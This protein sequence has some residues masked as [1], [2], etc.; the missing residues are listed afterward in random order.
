[1]GA[2]Q[3]AAV[4]DVSRGR[5]TVQAAAFVDS[6]L[7]TAHVL[8]SSFHGLKLPVID[9]VTARVV[10]TATSR[11]PEAALNANRVDAAACPGRLFGT[12]SGLVLRLSWLVGRMLGTVTASL[13]Y[14]N[15][16]VRTL[17]HVTLAV[18][19]QFKPPATVVD[20]R[21]AL[22]VGAH[23]L[24]NVTSSRSRISF[25]SPRTHNLS[26]KVVPSRAM[27][28]GVS[29]PTAGSFAR[30]RLGGSRYGRNILG[31]GTPF[32]VHIVM[33]AFY[34]SRQIVLT[35]EPR[36]AALGFISRRNN[37]D[38]GWAWTR[39]RNGVDVTL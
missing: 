34:L 3:P 23:G 39:I 1:M 10:S 4:Q 17:D 13:R 11:V 14:I 6:G 30:V 9:S 15:F 33:A 31:P 5:V 37:I 7:S 26:H 16:L 38:D 21:L 32:T 8:P 20:S 2:G 36:S 28:A 27:A 18:L 29:T 24:L 35:T 25:T 19:A 12:Q 22:A